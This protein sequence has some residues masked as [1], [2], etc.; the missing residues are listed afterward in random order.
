MIPVTRF[1][2]TELYINPDLIQTIEITPNTV[3]TFTND[4]KIVVEEPPEV[5]IERIIRFR[6]KVH[7]YES[8]EEIEE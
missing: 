2:G 5:I 7:S 4:H 3:I 8:A 1:K 6:A